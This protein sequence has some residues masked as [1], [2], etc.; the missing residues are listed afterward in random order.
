MLPAAPPIDRP[1]EGSGAALK[2]QILRAT[3]SAA[4]AAWLLFVPTV[5]AS[6]VPVGTRHSAEIEALTARFAPLAAEKGRKLV[7][8]D[9]DREVHALAALAAADPRDGLDGNS[10]GSFGTLREAS[11]TGHEIGSTS[12]RDRVCQYV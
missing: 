9:Q 8:F 6:E 3:V 4:L 2:R 7:I 10:I 5:A 1:V 11:S 12:C